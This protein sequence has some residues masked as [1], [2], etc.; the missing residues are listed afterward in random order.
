MIGFPGAEQSLDPD[1]SWLEKAYIRCLGVPISGLRIRLRRVLPATRGSYRKILDAGC[2]LGVFTMELAKQQ[3]E[4]EVLGIDIDEAA[5]RRAALIAERAGISN[6]RFL[7]GDVT[8]LGIS[9]EFDLVLSVDNLEHVED[10]VRAMRNLRAALKPG[11]TL[12]VHVPGY[13]RRWLMFG[14]RVNFHVPGHVRPGYTAERLTAKLEQAGFEV[15]EHRYTYGALET[16]TNNISY[17]ISGAERRNR[18]LYAVVFPLLLA[19]SY[20]GKFLRPRWGAGLL[21]T[22]RRPGPGNRGVATSGQSQDSMGRTGHN[23]TDRS[24]RYRP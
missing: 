7:V 13:Y 4:A 19:V 15:L 9:S 8:D 3:P 23:E 24:T 11:G 14:R 18:Q 10:D 22:A 20:F 2:G 12:V 17:L 5:V 6:C 1:L 16:F 21:A